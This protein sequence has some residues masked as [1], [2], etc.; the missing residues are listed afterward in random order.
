MKSFL[1]S[2]R[3][4][5]IQENKKQLDILKDAHAGLEIVNRGL[6]QYLEGKRNSFARFYFLGDNELIEILSETK[7]PN[8]VQIHLKKCFEGI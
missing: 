4:W 2:P 6:N 8:R 3:V 5:K 7:D 1:S